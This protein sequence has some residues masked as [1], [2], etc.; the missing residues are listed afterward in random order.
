MMQQGPAGLGYTQL[1]PRAGR[2][3]AAGPGN[4]ATSE[5]TQ[6]T[7]PVAANALGNLPG[8]AILNKSSNRPASPACRLLVEATYTRSDRLTV[9]AAPG[10]RRERP[11]VAA[12][13][14]R[15]APGRGPAVACV[16]CVGS[17]I[18]IGGPVPAH[19]GRRRPGHR[20]PSPG[21]PR[22]SAGPR[23][24]PPSGPRHTGPG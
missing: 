7:M 15:G 12:R 24:R 18:P 11:A 17:P 6:G 20:E 21:P 19:A 16:R 3:A 23:T 9:S 1:S 2:V 14:R 8:R 5:L 13:L 22:L 4:T 10:D